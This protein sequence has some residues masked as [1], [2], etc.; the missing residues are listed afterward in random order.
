MSHSPTLALCVEVL[1]T[2]L[3]AAAAAVA[4]ASALVVVYLAAGYFIFSMHRFH[5]C[6][7]SPVG[8]CK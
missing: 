2:E 4:T 7:C 3:V 6:F 5:G 8:G 1:Q